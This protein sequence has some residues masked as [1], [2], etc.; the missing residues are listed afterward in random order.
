MEKTRIAIGVP[1]F[2]SAD[3]IQDLLTSIMCYTNYSK[4]E[5]KI[6]II[7][8]GTY[9][10]I[11]LGELRK[12]CNKFHVPLIEHTENLGIPAAW[13]LLTK[14]YDCE[15]VVLFNDDIQ[16]IDPNWL[17][18]LIYFLQENDRVGA[19][20]F[21]LVHFDPSTKKLRKDTIK[22][23]VNVQPGKVG[24]PV[25]CAFG[26]KR[27]NF[28]LV[29][30]FPECITSF[31]EETWFGFELIKKGF[32]NFQMPYPIVEHWGSQT[33]GQ[34]ITLGVQKPNSKYL[35]MEEFKSIMKQKNYP[36]DRIEP[37][38]GYV[39]RMEYS[40]M[41]FAK[42]FNAKDYWHQPQVEVHQRLLYNI[43]P[44]KIK[45]LDKNMKPQEALL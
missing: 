43:D 33:F 28:D 8:D 41:L 19:I 34:N 38:S 1:T 30:G 45:W 36:D 20:G 3:R 18:C 10:K 22:P 13:N 32:L 11:V 6:I 40:R 5:Y 21:P 14:Y 37:I 16:V 23:D 12:V 15:Y 27:K 44:V 26:F 17:E 31:Y 39:Y 29:G 42:H 9:N 24:A 35:S 2:N 25:G 4:K 7:D